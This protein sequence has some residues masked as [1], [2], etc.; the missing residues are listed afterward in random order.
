MDSIERNAAAI[1]L[2]GK[3]QPT[4][5]FVILVTGLTGVGKSTFIN[6]LLKEPSLDLPV[7]HKQ[8]PCT[9]ELREVEIENHK[10]RRVYIVDTPGFNSTD[11]YD[12]DILKKIAAWLKNRSP[13]QPIDGGVIYLHNIQDDHYSTL[14]DTDLSILRNS[15]GQLQ[16][17]L[18]RIVLATTKW[19][20][21][22]ID[23][24]RRRQ[25]ELQEKHWK[26]L[27]AGGTSVME[28]RNDHDSAKEIVETLLKNSDKPLSFDIKTKLDELM[29]IQTD[30]SSHSVLKFLRFF[31]LFSR[32]S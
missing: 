12:L 25:L 6:S 18:G 23:E 8:D 30:T 4:T 28:F 11:A 19:H 13:E 14:T 22:N 29:Q 17:T 16:E 26:A 24:S 15:F 7:G 9:K 3:D 5:D 21:S 27:L 31:G 2:N 32:Y 1:A 10:G 20:R